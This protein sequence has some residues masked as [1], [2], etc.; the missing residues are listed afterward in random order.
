MPTTIT[1]TIAD[2]D[3]PRIQAA[4]AATG[5]TP[6]QLLINYAV[7]LVQSYEQQQN[8]VGYA[9]TYTPITPS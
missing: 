3:L 8:A 9:K 2:A 1:V 7:S 4:I 6:K 5:L